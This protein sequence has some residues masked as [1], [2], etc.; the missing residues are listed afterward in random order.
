MPARLGRRRR[1]PAQGC[2]ELADQFRL[3]TKVNA[4][5]AHDIAVLATLLARAGEVIE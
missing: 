4:V 3:L 5:K 2:D 1:L